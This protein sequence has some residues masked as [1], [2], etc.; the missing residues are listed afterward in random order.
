M[1][2]LTH[3]DI[4][5]ADV[6]ALVNTVNCVGV[7]GRGIALQFKNTFPEN[8]EFYRRAC[9][10]AEFHPGMMLIY[11]TGHIGNPKYVINFPTKRHW[12]AKSRMEDIDSGLKALVAEVRE[13]NIQSIAIP[14]LGCGLGGL[15]W[16]EVR[17]KI[18]AAFAALPRV[19][20][21][22]YEP[23]GAPAPAQMAKP[24]KAPKMTRGRA[25][26]L[27]LMRRYLSAVMEPFV[28]LLEIHKLMYFMQEA[29]EPLKLEYKP[30]RYGP[31]AE[32]LRHVLKH[33][34]GYFISGFGD[35]ADD[36]TREIQLKP[37]AAEAAEA[38]LADHPDTR[39]HFERVVNL[40]EGFETS[41]SMELL[42]TV[43]WVGKHGGAHTAE[44]AIVHTYAWNDRKRMFKEQHIRTAWETLTT[45]GWLV[46]AKP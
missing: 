46:S 16:E 20:V 35:A 12:K 7:M 17:P 22:L 1:I 42:A 30:A 36:P 32:N 3:G 15:N 6:E 23:K 41:F 9:E 8:Y 38:F 21:L 37:E 18:E 26:L 34:E 4:L 13:R 31:Y 14:P 24:H 19:R 39:L 44:E 10:R 5:D 43:H 45:K 27:G 40:I 25:A 29:G 11:E 2:E 33:I 28:T